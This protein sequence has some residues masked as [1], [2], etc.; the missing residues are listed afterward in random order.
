MAELF[1]TVLI[2][3]ALGVAIT[4]LLLILK[5][6][7]S[8]K[9]SAGWQYYVWIC[10]LIMMIFPA[11]KLIPEKA[12]HNFP[13]ILRN[14]ST[15]TETENI[16][17]EPSESVIIDEQ[18]TEK[19]DK[20]FIKKSK[21]NLLDLSAY[22][23]ICG[24]AVYLFIIIGSYIVYNFRKRK[25]SILIT[26]NEIL[27][28]T[29]KELKIKRHIRI[30]MSPDIH[31]PILAGILFPVIYIPARDIP[32]ENMRMIFLHELSHYKRKD[33]IIKWFSLFVNAIHW[34]NPLAY[35][36][37]SNISE[38]CEISCDRKVTKNMS[39]AEQKLYM[40]TILELV[41]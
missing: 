24:A 11:Y 25:N 15:L 21:I 31:S 16:S 23:W 41:E 18:L 19:S 13:L 38:A 12:V 9:L 33:L 17:G 26:E 30:K 40:K 27:T 34:F 7:T 28:K 36:I 4:A 5:P 22:I 10:V 3:S 1:K 20:S 2:M 14:E 32:D 6:F 39:E 8:K 35:L 37:C 29:K